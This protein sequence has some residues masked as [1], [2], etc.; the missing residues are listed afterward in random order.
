MTVDRPLASVA[1]AISSRLQTFI[2]DENY[3]E[4]NTSPQPMPF[5]ESTECILVPISEIDSIEVL[6]LLPL[7]Q[8][9]KKDFPIWNGFSDQLSILFREKRIDPRIKYN[10]FYSN[11]A[12]DIVAL[13][14]WKGR[15]LFSLAG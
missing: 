2:Q 6:S 10:Q 13:Y 1:R 4:G 7:L 11:N 3:V 5:V 12:A 14:P 15:S 8:A 9:I